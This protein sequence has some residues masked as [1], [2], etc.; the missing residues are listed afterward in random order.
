VL[1]VTINAAGFVTQT[2]FAPLPLVVLG[3][4]SVWYVGALRRLEPSARWDPWRTAAWFLGIAI[5]AFSL[6][7]G[8]AGWDANS[9]TIH[10]G[11]DAAVGMVAP[12]ALAL[13]APLTLAR[14]G[15]GRLA[16][17][18][19]FALTEGKAG[20]WVFHPLLVWVL[21]TASLFGLYLLPVY[22]HTRGHLVLLELG[23]FEFA[24]AGCLFIW[25][26]VGADRA[27]GRMGQGWRMAWLGFG[28]PYYSVFGEAI[29]SRSSPVAPGIGL[30]DLH[31]GGD[32]IWSAGEVISVGGMVALLFTWLFAELSRVRSEEVMDR[33]ALDLQA[34]MWRVS[35][36]L[37]KPE[38]QVAAERAA[39]IA[40]AT[41]PAKS[42]VPA[43]AKGRRGS[44]IPYRSDA[45]RSDADRGDGTDRWVPPGEL[46]R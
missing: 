33:E 25:P 37:A 43:R 19:G 4:L 13:G 6:L 10:A 1:A 26:L 17:S 28:I 32:I 36:I 2:P 34:S 29:L 12:F 46:D 15:G 21:Y 3:A 42:S 11:T 23:H 45:D 27:V 24:L 22:R 16:R 35:R 5:V 7:G 20:R 44:G 31:T 8:M 18:F 14:A 30:N 38:A 9:F 41:V 40:A 39:A